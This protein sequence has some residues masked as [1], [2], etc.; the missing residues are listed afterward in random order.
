MLL[1]RCKN[2]PSAV[3]CP[4][5]RHAEL[6]AQSGT[7]HSYFQKLHPVHRQSSSHHHSD[8]SKG[9]RTCRPS[10]HRNWGDD[11][12]PPT[13]KPRAK[14]T[15]HRHLPHPLVGTVADKLWTHDPGSLLSVVSH[16]KLVKISL[17]RMLTEQILI[18][19]F[20][21]FIPIFSDTCWASPRSTSFCFWGAAHV[22][23]KVTCHP[24]A[25]SLSHFETRKK[26]NTT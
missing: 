25:Q 1:W 22:P 21:W 5:H 7:C 14:G 4:C 18:E 15:E 26:R 6:S 19:Q 2:C 8:G 23:I 24:V 20:L 3:Y 17:R 16:L 11:T 10:P 13:R 12:E 9:N